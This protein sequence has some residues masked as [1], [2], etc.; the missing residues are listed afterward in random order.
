MYC[1][2]I[3]S[4]K[5]KGQQ[6]ILPAGKEVVMGR[7]EQCQVRLAAHGVSRRHCTLRRTDEGIA[8]RDLDSRNGTLVNETP[9]QNETLLKPGD[10]LQVGPLIFEVAERADEEL[11]AAGPRKPEGG[12]SP[13]VTSEDEVAGWLA[14][15]D[16]GAEE[17]G[18]TAVLA[19]GR[20][21]GSAAGPPAPKKEFESIAEEAADIIRRW[22]ET[23]GE[24]SSAD[25]ESGS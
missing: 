3:Q 8:A 19:K 20:G 6:L 15:P 9:I 14:E 11:P 23:T 16:E 18:E 7:S 12:A 1:L 10:R 25:R 17:G 24:Q 5:R 13:R 22:G 21:N 4:G 2:V